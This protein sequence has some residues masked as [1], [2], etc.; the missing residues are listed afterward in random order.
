FIG[1][2]S[3]IRLFYW[4]VWCIHIILLDGLWNH[5]IFLEGLV[6]LFFFIGLFCA[7]FLFYFIVLCNF[8]IYLDGIVIYIFVS[9]YFLDYFIL[10]IV[11]LY[12]FLCLDSYLLSNFLI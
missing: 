11:M 2:F 3:A 10:L 7:I 8:I 6:L 4:T 5:N 1:R 12:L 9:F